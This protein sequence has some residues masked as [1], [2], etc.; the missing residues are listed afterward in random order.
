MPS[1]PADLLNEG[2]RGYQL[3]KYW[4]SSIFKKISRWM[5]TIA[6]SPSLPFPSYLFLP[7]TESKTP[8]RQGSHLPLSKPPYIPSLT[9]L[10]PESRGWHFFVLYLQATGWNHPICL[11]CNFG[12][13]EPELMEEQKQLNPNCFSFHCPTE[14]G[15]D[16][17]GEV[18]E[19]SACALVWGLN[20]GQF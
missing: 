12:L 7:P 14:N 18:C 4:K 10:S 5:E 2:A 13:K 16:E 9:E 1:L 11:E 17:G 3:I 20:H 8:E 19:F 6:P 15:G